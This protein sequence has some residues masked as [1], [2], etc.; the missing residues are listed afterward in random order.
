MFY[1]LSG[2]VTHIEP[3]LAVIDCGGV[4]YACRTTS[5][6]LSALK[7]GDKGKLFTHL[8]VREDAMELYGFATQEELNLFQHLISVSGVGPKSALAVLSDMTPDQLSLAVA[9]G[10][11]KSLRNAPG[12]G[13]KVAQRIILELKDKLGTDGLA[14]GMQE[15]AAQLRSETTNMSEA[16]SALCVLGY[17][18]SEAARAL[19]GMA[20]DTPVDELI[21][22]GLKALSGGR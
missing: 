10:D 22:H 18:Q 1:Y 5:Y 13:P 14:E 8:N 21:K 9:S 17:S 11:A 3:Y 4:G 16:V 15:V 20:A 12:I 6:T 7:K 2:T 19:A